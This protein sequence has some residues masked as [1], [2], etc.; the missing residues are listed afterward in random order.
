MQIRGNFNKLINSSNKINLNKRENMRKLIW[1]V[2]ILTAA[3]SVH[4]TNKLNAIKSLEFARNA[5]TTLIIPF[6]K[7]RDAEIRKAAINSIAKIGNENYLLLLESMLNQGNPEFIPELLFAIAQIGT[8]RAENLLIGFY[9]KENSKG[10]EAQVYKAIGLC[11]KDPAAEFLKRQL[12]T[13]K[14]KDAATLI[15][16]LAFVAKRIND[17]QTISQFIKQY[18]NDP[19]EQARAAAAYYFSRIETPAAL[20]DLAAA[21]FKADSNAEKYR[22]KALS[23]I[24]ENTD[25]DSVWLQELKPQIAAILQSDKINWR[26]KFYAIDLL[27]LYTDSSSI[28]LL[29]DGLSHANPQ[30]R[31]QAVKTLSGIQGPYARTRLMA[32]YE[33]FSWAEKGQMIL[34][35]SATNPGLAYRL[36]QENLD[37]GSVYF[38]ELL[39]Q[40]LGNIG[41]RKGLDQLKQFLNVSEKRL[42]IA[43]FYE[44]QQK[45]EIGLSQIQTVLKSGDIVLTYLA[46]AWID[47]HPGLISTQDLKNAYALFDEEKDF[48]IQLK[49]LETMVQSDSVQSAIFLKQLVKTTENR[50]VYKFVSQRLDEMKISF[51]PREITQNNL[52][53]PD[54]LTASDQAVFAEIKT[55]HGTVKIKLFPRAAPATVTNF[56]RL[57]ENGYF[58]GLTFHRV[59]PDFVV[60]GGDPR[61][62]GWGGPGYSIPCEYNSIEYTRGSVGMATS[63]KDTG[64]SQFFIC[65]SEQPHLTG[66]YTLFGQVSEGMEI[67]D[68]ITKDDKILTVTIIVQEE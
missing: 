59:V 9:G 15:T 21:R 65:Q 58:N 13:G 31:L 30:I 8:D 43:A 32:R 63:G 26:I 41:D 11:G 68:K 19:N 54:S 45:S 27:K 61:G 67:V 33:Q 52:F 60:Q 34:G 35:F 48:E 25:P 66:H 6:L 23:K 7:D 42:R 2:M 3:C 28:D 49:I 29:A 62:D 56:V 55:E 4:D 18:L 14:N 24:T 57:S 44:L 53:V 5:D 12:L 1:A 46:A 36:A 16:S 22:L 17:P 38:K 20:N 39:L 40:S 64:G 47:E 37:K 50:D 51:E 10:F